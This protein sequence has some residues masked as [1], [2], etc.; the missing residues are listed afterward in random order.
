[1]SSRFTI[2]YLKTAEKDLDDIFD[3]IERDNPQS[4]PSM[5]EKFDQAIS[6]LA[7]T[8]EMGAQPR[9]DRMRKLGYRTLVV[10]DYLVFYVVKPGARTVQIG[11]IIHGARQYG[12]LL[13]E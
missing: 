9:D 2:R 3:Y 8:P 5:L 12:F 13:Q 4:A 6:R 7:D 10:G 11:R 1:M